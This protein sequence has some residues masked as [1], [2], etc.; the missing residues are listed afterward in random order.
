AQQ[1]AV[2]L[3]ELRPPLPPAGVR[4]AVGAPV[5]RVSLELTAQL[6]ELGV[7]RAAGPPLAATADAVVHERTELGPHRGSEVTP[8]SGLARVEALGD[9]HPGHDLDRRGELGRA[10]PP[11]LAVDHEHRGSGAVELLDG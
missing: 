5:A 11:D 9:P 2:L 8:G 1:G 10:E 4:L 7:V 6:L 3:V